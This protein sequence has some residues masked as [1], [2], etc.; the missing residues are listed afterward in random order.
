MDDDGFTMV[1]KPKARHLLPD[2]GTVVQRPDVFSRRSQFIP[3]NGDMLASDED[4]ALKLGDLHLTQDMID[5]AWHGNGTGA[6]ARGLIIA[7]TVKQG[8][9]LTL[10]QTVQRVQG[11]LKGPAAKKHLL[12]INV[13]WGSRADDDSLATLT[14]LHYFLQFWTDMLLASSIHPDRCLHI[15][16]LYE[17]LSGYPTDMWPCLLHMTDL[18]AHGTG[19]T[20]TLRKLMGTPAFLSLF[21]QHRL[22]LLSTAFSSAAGYAKEGIFQTRTR[23]KNVLEGISRPAEYH[24]AR[25]TFVTTHAHTF[26]AAINTHYGERWTVSLPQATHI[27]NTLYFSACEYKDGGEALSQWIALQVPTLFRDTHATSPIPAL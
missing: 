25:K 26:M 4:I 10:A 24:D 2:L 6:L 11:R 19:N 16:A 12:T 21:D 15:D 7:F 1:S 18:A 27:L 22:T 20:A 3:V 17:S 9:P 14:P 5:V 13:A 23:P 8:L